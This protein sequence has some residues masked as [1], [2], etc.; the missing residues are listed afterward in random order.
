[1]K[2]KGFSKKIGDLDATKG[3]IQ[4]LLDT[5]ERRIAADLEGAEDVAVW[6]Y[7]ARRL[8][9]RGSG[10]TLREVFGLSA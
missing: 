6:D 5:R 2:K 7:S 4:R 3:E 9:A 1:M 10:T 8:S